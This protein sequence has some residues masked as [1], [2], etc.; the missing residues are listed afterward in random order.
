MAVIDKYAKDNGYTLIMDVS[1]QQ[2]NVVYA[3]S[4]IDVTRE[5][6]EMYDKNA[7]TIVPAPKPAAPKPVTPTPAP[8]KPTGSK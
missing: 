2:T 8:P 1:S 6:I 7:G 5:V 4:A 3:A